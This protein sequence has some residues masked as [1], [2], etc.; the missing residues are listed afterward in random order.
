MKNKELNPCKCRSTKELELNSYDMVP[1]WG[2]RCFSCGQFQHGE[3]W[4]RNGAINKWNEENPK[5]ETRK[6]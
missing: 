6:D 3:N 2:V 1:C 5:N 4:D